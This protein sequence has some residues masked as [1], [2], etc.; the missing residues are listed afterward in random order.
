MIKFICFFKFWRLH[1]QID[2]AL[3]SDVPGVSKSSKIT[4]I[5]GMSLILRCI[6]G[7][8]NNQTK[9]FKYEKKELLC[10]GAGDGSG[11]HRFCRV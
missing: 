1:L 2:S 9:H 11:L 10:G 4:K 5:L 3:Q 8:G 6:A 7:Y